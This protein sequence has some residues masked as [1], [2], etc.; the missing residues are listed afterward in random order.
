MCVYIY[1]VLSSNVIILL[2]VDFL[3]AWTCLYMYIFMHFL[4]SFLHI[5]YTF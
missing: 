2:D 4:L 5:L 1:Y 3:D